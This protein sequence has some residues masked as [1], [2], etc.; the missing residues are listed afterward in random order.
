MI[1]VTASGVSGWPSRSRLAA[2]RRD[3]ARE[4]FLR[5]PGLLEPSLLER[6]LAAVAA[7]RFAAPERSAGLIA[8]EGATRREADLLLTFLL[9]QPRLFEFVEAVTGCPR[10][11][12]FGGRLIR[13]RPGSGHF[14]DWHSDAE[15]DGA[16]LASISLNLGREPYLGGVL[17]F[18]PRRG[19]R[20][21][22]EIANVGCGDAVLFSAA[23]DAVHR[24]TP[25]RGRRAKVAFSGWF[26]G[27]RRGDVPMFHHPPPGRP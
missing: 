26:Y 3:F 22:S 16:R 9:Q 11:R 8:V 20:V 18:R 10:V 25:L 17:Q 12:S 4:R 21:R 27:D 15:F 23:G 1:Q 5:L 14:L 24:N 13:Q 7:C 19:R 6:V 2:L